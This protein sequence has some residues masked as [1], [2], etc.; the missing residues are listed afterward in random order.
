MSSPLA[1]LFTPCR[2]GTWACYS[3]LP[4]FCGSGLLHQTQ[5]GQSGELMLRR[6][7]GSGI[8]HGCRNNHID[9]LTTLL[10]LKIL[11]GLYAPDPGSHDPKVA[12]CVWNFRRC[13]Y[14]GDPSLAAQACPPGLNFTRCCPLYRCS[15]DPLTIPPQ[16]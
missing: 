11:I 3:S 13:W 4:V 14:R 2:S 6:T 7:A 8:S 10:F 16:Q 9:V 1:Y 12:I 15:L 5:I